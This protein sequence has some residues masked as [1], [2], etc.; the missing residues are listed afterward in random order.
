MRRR[1]APLPPARHGVSLVEALVA[2]AVMS[3]GMLALI[4][5]QSTM[6]INTDLSRQTTEATRIASEDL[7]SLRLFVDVRALQNQP[8]PSW[9]DLADRA[10]DVQLPGNTGNVSFSLART[11]VMFPQRPERMAQLAITASQAKIAQTTVTW[12]DRTETL[13]TVRLQ[14][15]VA[16]AAPVLSGMVSLPAKADAPSRRYNRHPTIP[17]TARDL[18]D[19]RSQFQPSATSF[20]T[21]FFNNSTGLVTSCPSADSLPEN[22]KV[23]QLLAGTVQFDLLDGPA[24]SLN[25]RG[26]GDRTVELAYRNSATGSLDRTKP[27]LISDRY[28]LPNDEPYMQCFVTQPL[29]GTPRSAIDY[30]CVMFRLDSSGWGGKVDPAVSLVGLKVCRY[31]EALTDFT[32][33]PKHPRTYCKVAS[34]TCATNNRVRTN[35]NHQNFLVVAASSDCPSSIQNGIALR[36]NTLPHPASQ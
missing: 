34:N 26:V 28:G 1:L 15:V 11:L 10:A 24:D 16:A 8:V 22:C 5:V 4:G 20:A 35:L 9:D 33:N 30:A 21:W 29:Y 3:F 7:E 13:R 14:G 12:T 25:P 23:G 32:L 2:L 6:R 18:G 31:T 19:G 17:A 36:G 27:L